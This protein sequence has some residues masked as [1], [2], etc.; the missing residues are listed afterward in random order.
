MV[1]VVIA[2]VLL[3]SVTGCAAMKV[4]VV[5]EQTG[6]PIPNTRVTA[7]PM[8]IFPLGM[9]DRDDAFTDESGIVVLRNRRLDMSVISVDGLDKALAYD[10]VIR[11]GP[12][13]SNGKIRVEYAGPGLGWP[14]RGS[15]SSKKD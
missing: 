6:L 2:S 14:I 15:N 9:P 1:R 10:N 4:R 13:T 3:V 12:E 8:G 5:D 11:S 7:T